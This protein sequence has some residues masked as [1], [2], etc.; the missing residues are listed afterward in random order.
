MKPVVIKRMLG[1]VGEAFVRLGAEL[2]IDVADSPV[3]KQKHSD[4]QPQSQGT[5][6]TPAGAFQGP[7]LERKSR[8]QS[9]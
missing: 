7:D 5:K 4:P 9:A 3:Q 2:E 8:P 6:T 1:A